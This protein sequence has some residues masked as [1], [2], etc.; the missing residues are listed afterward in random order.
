MK[1]LKILFIILILI[2]AIII[3]IGLFLPSEI[4]VERTVTINAPPSQIF[5]QINNFRNWSNWTAWAKKD[6]NMTNTY[7]GSETGEGSIYKWSG[8]ENVGNG[9]LTMTKSD[10]NQ[11][12]WYNMSMEDGQFQ[13]KG[14]ITYEPMGDQ[15]NVKWGYQ[16]NAGSNILFKYVM[17]FFKPYIEHDF[18]EGLQGLKSL[19]ESDSTMHQIEADSINENY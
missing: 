2:I 10:S 3:V 7:E 16:A 8:N 4:S 5:N 14:Y 17:V 1:V 15:T 11:G 6:T 9:I 12:I 18:D 19:V 13:S